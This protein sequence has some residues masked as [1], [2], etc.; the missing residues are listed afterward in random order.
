MPWKRIIAEFGVIFA[1]VTFGLLAEGW[2]Q[3]RSNASAA[4]DLLAEVQQDLRAD[5][6]EL[7]NIRS[8]S[9]RWDES[10][11]RF[12]ELLPD[13]GADPDSLGEAVKRLQ[14]YTDFQSVSAGYLAIQDAGLISDI[15]DAEVRRA[16]IGYYEQTQVSIAGF[17]TDLASARIDFTH[18]SRRHFAFSRPEQ[19]TSIVQSVGLQLVGTHRDLVADHDLRG[20]AEYEGM[21]AAVM[22]QMIIPPAMDSNQR[23]SDLIRDLRLRR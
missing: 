15:P 18:A 19:I 13:P 14:Q 4:M 9:V 22:G 7:A 20:A 21:I 5:S 17:W 3:D 1:G 12:L 6:I 2:W 10:A 16:L 23:L 11:V 8:W